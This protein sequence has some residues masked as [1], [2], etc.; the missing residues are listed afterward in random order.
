MGSLESTEQIGQ[1]L[2]TV[3]SELRE[4]LGEDLLSL[5]HFGN[6]LQSPSCCHSNDPIQILVVVERI[7]VDVLD[8]IAKAI[9]SAR[10]RCEIMPMV[11]T[12]LEIQQSLDVFPT[13]YLEIQSKHE[14][15]AGENLL[16][17]ASIEPS[18]LRIRCE[19]ELKNTLLR[20][21]AGYVS[22]FESRKEL[23]A[24][25]HRSIRSLI[26]TLRCVQVLFDKPYE[27]NDD[28]LIRESGNQLEFEAEQ[29]LQ[30]SRIDEQQKPPAVA[31]ARELVWNLMEVLSSIA[32][33]VDRIPDQ[34]EFLEVDED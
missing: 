2:K 31:V 26:R 32:A 13:T 11:V 27:L 22:H 34:V 20:L 6:H 10:G 18:Y 7:T 25:F 15:L 33:A 14:L 19:Q 24:L 5:L 4:K 1:R 8:G 30:L 21:Q 17:Q 23:C 16:A 28:K 3:S 12:P 29:L 9:R